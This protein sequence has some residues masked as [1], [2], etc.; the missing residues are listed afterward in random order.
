MFCIELVS[1]PIGR[2]IQLNTKQEELTNLRGKRK[3]RMQLL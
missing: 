1:Y 2:L 3:C